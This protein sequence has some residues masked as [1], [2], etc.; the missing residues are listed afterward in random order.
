MKIYS[1]KKKI[2]SKLIFQTNNFFLNKKYV[3]YI[4]LFDKYSFDFCKYFVE[5]IF[6]E[7]IFKKYY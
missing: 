2:I 1:K 5:F 6:I 4:C 7:R 3:L